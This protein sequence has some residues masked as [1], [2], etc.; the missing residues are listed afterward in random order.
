MRK[1]DL[2]KLAEELNELTDLKGREDDLRFLKK[3]YIRLSNR[4]EETYFE[5]M[6]TDK[7]NK[8]Y[9]SLASKVPELNRSSKMFKR[10]R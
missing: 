10:T 5:K 7:F 2:I 9:E 3:E 6:L 8:A 1:E 4:D